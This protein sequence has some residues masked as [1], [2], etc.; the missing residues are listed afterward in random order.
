MTS[1]LERRRRFTAVV[2]EVYEPLQRYLLRRASSAD[3]ADVLNDT[4]LVLWRR[5][6]DVP[7]AALPYAYGVARRSLANH[8]RAA[9]RHLRLVRRLAGQRDDHGPDP[10]ATIEQTDPA[11]TAALGT[12]TPAER[13]IVHLWAWESLEPREIAAVVGTTANAVSVALN[14]ARRK[15]ADRLGRQDPTSRGHTGIGH[16]EEQEETQR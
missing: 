2:D 9:G 5:L 12:L 15:L 3:A 6:D 4:L 10:A 14:R 16:A 1:E 13:E 8:R 11:L 7:A